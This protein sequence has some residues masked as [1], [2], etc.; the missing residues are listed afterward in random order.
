M[1]VFAIE[2]TREFLAL[3]FSPGDEESSVRLALL[4]RVL[5]KLSLT[6]DECNQSA[7]PGG[8]PGIPV[9]QQALRDCIVQAFPTLGHHA[10]ILP[11]A[12]ATS[13]PT[14]GDAVD[15]LVEI[16]A[17]L[18][19]IESYWHRKAPDE[20]KAYFAFTFRTHWGRHLLNLRSYLHNLKFKN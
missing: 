18:M 1:T 10:A 8:E 11:D 20:A 4:S 14:I 19:Q 15:D 6:F 5:D 12:A 16:A 2:S 7:L 17:E 3:I 9:E 13:S